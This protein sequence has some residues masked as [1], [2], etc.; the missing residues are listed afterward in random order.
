MIAIRL[1]YLNG[2]GKMFFDKVSAD[3]KPH[4]TGLKK[5]LGDLEADIMEIIWQKNPA[6]V[7]DVYETLRLERE[8][9]YTTVM[10]IMGRLAE[11]ELLIKSPKGNAYLYTPAISKKEFSK[12]VVSA[13]IDGLLDEF[14]EPALSHFI[15]RLSKADQNKIAE[16][17][18]LIKA[19]KQ[20]EDQ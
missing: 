4:K 11:K 8:I 19:K 9:A 2:G 14:A 13:V 1:S 17:E 5:V 7:R 6:S 12:K 15:D 20:Q 10:T 18:E 3:F 16:L